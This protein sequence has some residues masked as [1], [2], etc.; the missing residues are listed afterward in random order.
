MDVNAELGL[1]RTL[2]INE[3]VYLIRI[4]FKCVLMPIHG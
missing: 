4:Y 3:E 2:R 1:T